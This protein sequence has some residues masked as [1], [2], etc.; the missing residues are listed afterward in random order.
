[1]SA[2]WRPG[3]C[4]ECKKNPAGDDQLCSSCRFNLEYGESHTTLA[5]AGVPDDKGV[6][7]WFDPRFV[8]NEHPGT[9]SRSWNTEKDRKPFY[10]AQS[11][12]AYSY[13][14]SL[15]EQKRW[16]VWPLDN[17][18]YCGK[19]PVFS[20]RMRLCKEHYRED[21]RAKNRKR[22]S[23]YWHKHHLKTN[24]KSAYNTRGRPNAL[25]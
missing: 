24:G 19:R 22:V 21:Q 10:V 4:L 7:S 1:M 17:A 14:K 20:V 11:T 3:R 15:N 16:C 2:K 12:S 25:C 8:S 6:G 9:V 5:G 18:R 23:K 13:L